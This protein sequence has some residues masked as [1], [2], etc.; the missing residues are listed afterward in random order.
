MDKRSDNAYT[1]EDEGR[2][3]DR[4]SD[5]IKEVT[6]QVLPFI[7]LFPMRNMQGAHLITSLPPAILLYNLR[8]AIAMVEAGATTG[9]IHVDNDGKVSE[10]SVEDTVT[11]MQKD[12]LQ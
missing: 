4:V 8:E 1:V 6:G 2:I 5:A 12:K 7:L 11:M 10:L 9:G 3:A